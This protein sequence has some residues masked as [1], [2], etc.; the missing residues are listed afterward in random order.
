MVAVLRLGGGGLGT[1]SWNPKEFP[2]QMVPPPCWCPWQVGHD[3]CALIG[4]ALAGMF[5]Q[6]CPPCPP[7][8]V[9]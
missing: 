2:T 7:T 9:P 3:R 1:S 5:S 4:C 6:V 8:G